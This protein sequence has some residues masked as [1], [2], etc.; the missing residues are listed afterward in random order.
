MDLVGAI[1]RT[2][3]GVPTLFTDTQTSVMQKL[4]VWFDGIWNLAMGKEREDNLTDVL[5]RYLRLQNM[6][7]GL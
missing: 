2:Y 4:V 5:R 7:A 1:A 3:A 6:S